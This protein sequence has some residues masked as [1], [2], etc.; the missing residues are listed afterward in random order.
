MSS[1]PPNDK[2][3]LP[4]LVAFA[5]RHSAVIFFLM[6]LA[7]ASFE[8]VALFA[9]K[10]RD[11]GKA[12]LAPDQVA[13]AV[14]RNA[15]IWTG[16]SAQPSAEALVVR[17]GRLL[18][19]GASDSSERFVGPNIVVVDLEG[20]R[21][22]PGFIDAHWHLSTTSS[23]DLSG[24][25][26]VAEIGTRLA[27]W[28]EGRAGDA[29]VLGRGW[30][31]TDFPDRQPHRRHLDAMYADRPVLLTDRDGHQVLANSALLRLANITRSTPDPAGGRIVRDTD[32]SPTGVLQEAAASLV[33][34]LVPPPSTD[35][36][37][38]RVD[39]LSREAAAYGITMLHEM[40]GRAPQGAVFDAL[41]T[42]AQA[43]TLRQRWYVSVPFNPDIADSTLA[44]YVALTDSLRGPWLRFWVAKGMLDGTVDAR[45]AAM[46]S[47]YVGTSDR[48]LPFIAD[49]AL[50]RGVQRYDSAGLQVAL[51][52]I[53]D[54][55]VRQAL[56]A[57]ET[58][59]RK[60]GVRDTRH[61]IEHVEVP[62][63]QDVPRFRTL[64][65]VASTQALFATPDVTTLEN[66]APLLG[67]ERAAR[68]NHFKQFDDAGVVQAFGSDHPVFPMQVMRGIHVAVN[69][70]TVEG[71]PR[72]G[73][74]PEGRISLE[75]ALRHF[76]RDAAY[77]AFLEE[78]VGTLRAGML[79]DFVVLDRD[80][81]AL[82]TD[83]LFTVQVER[84]V[85]GG[86]MTYRRDSSSRGAVEARPTRPR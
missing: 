37:A 32:G 30:T 85:V 9:A 81:F 43:D 57:F 38:R 82:P 56:D 11:A 64:G 68:S 52:A 65:V 48:G 8:G 80:P 17:D 84:T 60:N 2:D 31:A 67:P 12:T 27:K 25:G 40:S 6:L 28:A 50:T 76:T 10:R 15:R 46:L 20:R 72:G 77:A 54:R 51:H 35:D 73:W 61:R 3:D 1:T 13:D 49:A 26:S 42:A 41:R 19:V 39:E 79:A 4:P 59:R 55:A 78:Q 83:S 22:V 34:R 66:Y 53:G 44:R 21:V 47:P 14:Y 71:T 5:S 62:D 18:F 23:A 58:A 86:R 7:V 16:D 69:R 74:Y 70:T 45:T 24:A 75:A 29:W 63:P 33:R 36:V